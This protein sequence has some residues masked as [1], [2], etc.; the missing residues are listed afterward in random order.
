M[1]AVGFVELAGVP[2]L[3]RSHDSSPLPAG[4]HQSEG[5]LCAPEEEGGRRMRTAARP[6]A[7]QCGLQAGARASYEE[8]NQVM[9][10]H[11][12]KWREI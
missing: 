11:Y 1:A 5:E 9:N 4:F 6:H 3:D 7:R 12:S 8:I 10:E 2:E